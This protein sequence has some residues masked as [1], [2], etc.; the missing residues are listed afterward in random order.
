MD[1]DDALEHLRA[2]LVA[3]VERWSGEMARHYERADEF[4][5]VAR[6]VRAGMGHGVGECI[7]ELC[8]V[9]GIPVPGDP[10]GSE[11]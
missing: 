7:V 8:G 5:G 10:E 6:H 1:T 11:R 2:Q 9:L 4:T 3:L